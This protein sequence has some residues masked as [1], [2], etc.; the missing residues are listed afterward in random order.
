MTLIKHEWIGL[1][2]GKTPLF[3]SK[4]QWITF[5]SRLRREQFTEELKGTGKPV[6][7]DSFYC[8]VNRLPK[9]MAT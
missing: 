6:C 2:E 7:K 5:F 4:A 9:E 8:T 3:T 1:E